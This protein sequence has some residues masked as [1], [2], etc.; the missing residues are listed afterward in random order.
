MNSKGTPGMLEPVAL[1][2][3][4]MGRRN[5]T[6]GYSPGGS[7]RPPALGGRSPQSSFD[8]NGDVGQISL[9]FM[10][11][12][13]TYAPFKTLL[14]KD[15]PKVL[16]QGKDLNVACNNVGAAP[17]TTVIPSNGIS[18]VGSCHTPFNID[19][20]TKRKESWDQSYPGRKNS[21]PIRISIDAGRS[22][23]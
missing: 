4:Y 23:R 19:P 1:E 13:G 18:R 12:N 14:T 10:R 16:P 11:V 7:T 6:S 15:Q 17:T 5:S 20:V 9:N 2:Y 22:L 3:G 8:S 21:D